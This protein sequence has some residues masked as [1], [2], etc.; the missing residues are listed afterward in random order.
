MKYK[1]WIAFLLTAVLCI[2]VLGGCGTQKK[3]ICLL[4]LQK[5]R[6]SLISLWRTEKC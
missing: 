3:K 5:M 1:K 2:G 4:V 6:S